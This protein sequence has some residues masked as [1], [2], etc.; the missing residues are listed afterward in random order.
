MYNTDVPIVQ[1]NQ[2]EEHPS[3]SRPTTSCNTFWIPTTFKLH[4]CSS[5][6]MSHILTPTAPISMSS[7]GLND[8]PS[9]RLKFSTVPINS[10]FHELLA[11][12]PIQFHAC[13]VN[14]W[15]VILWLVHGPPSAR[16]NLSNCPILVELDYSCME[17]KTA[18]ATHKKCCD[19]VYRLAMSS[20]TWVDVMQ[21]SLILIL[22][23]VCG[24]LHIRYP[25]NA[26]VY[27]KTAILFN[28]C[29]HYFYHWGKRFSIFHPVFEFSRKSLAGAH[30][31]TTRRMQ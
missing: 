15:N 9:S 11:D 13:I 20:V 30:R 22:W 7:Y 19:L 12:V 27:G 8:D 25:I 6:F 4:G 28:L 17:L 23:H 1:L 14:I 24:S 21:D 31:R 10:T 29:L 26:A 2:D 5:T 18:T 16:P 3:I